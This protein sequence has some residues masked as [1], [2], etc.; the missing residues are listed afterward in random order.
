MFGPGTYAVPINDVYLIIYIRDE[1]VFKALLDNSYRV[2]EE[3]VIGSQRELAECCS[4]VTLAELADP[5]YS[6]QA[7]MRGVA[8]AA[9]YDVPNSI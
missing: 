5:K 6:S 2:I 4:R 8:Y 9:S 3:V 7:T 1:L